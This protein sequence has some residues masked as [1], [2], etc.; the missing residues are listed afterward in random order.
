MCMLKLES[1]LANAPVIFLIPGFS[2]KW[3]YINIMLTFKM[4]YG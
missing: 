1:H 3:Q 4:F 2:A